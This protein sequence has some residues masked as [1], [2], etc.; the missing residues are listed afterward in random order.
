MQ[1]TVDRARWRAH[2][3]GIDAIDRRAV[4]LE[5]MRELEGEARFSDGARALYANDGSSYRQVP[6]GVV[7]PHHADD[8]AATV[9]ICRRHGAPIGSRG[10]GTGLAGQTVNEVVMVDFSKYMRSIV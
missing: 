10:A 9:D 2:P 1:I 5:L 7:V 4:A 6:L 8:V 3:A